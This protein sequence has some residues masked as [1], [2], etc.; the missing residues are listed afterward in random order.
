MADNE[1]IALIEARLDKT[2]L[3]NEDIPK[4]QTRLDKKKFTAHIENFKLNT[5]N[6][7]NQIQASLDSHKFTIY[8]DGIKMNDIDKQATAAG[9]KYSNSFA[10]A[11]KN[12]E[13]N[14]FVGLDA[15]LASVENRFG[16]VAN[17]GHQMTSKIGRHIQTLK[18]DIDAI[19]NASND[20][21]R[22][23]YFEKYKLDLQRVNDELKIV[24]NEID[25]LLNK[26]HKMTSRGSVGFDSSFN[27]L[28][29]QLKDLESK[30]ASGLSSIKSELQNVKT[31]ADLVLN[32]KDVDHQ[33][34]AFELWENAIRSV[35][36]QLKSAATTIDPAYK[37]MKEMVGFGENKFKSITE[38]LRSKAKTTSF[39][40]TEITS[41]EIEDDLKELE[42]LQKNIF[43]ASKSADQL[44]NWKKFENLVDRITDKLNL[45][46][47]TSKAYV[48]SFKLTKVDNKFED[49]LKRNT[50]A[51][52][53]FGDQIDDIKSKIKLLMDNAVDGRVSADGYNEVVQAIDKVQS[54]AKSTGKIG[55]KF[56][57]QLGNAFKKFS[58]YFTVFDAFNKAR[59]MIHAMYE[60][61]LAVDTAMTNL[62]KVTDETDARY[63]S[64]LKNAT[65]TAQELGRTV[66]GYV[67]Q[68]SEWA[69]LGYSLG[70]SEELSK[71][72]S[73]YA[74]VGDIDD[75]QAVSDMVTALKAFRIE[76]TDAIKV[77]D[78]LNELGELYCPYRI[79]RLASSYIG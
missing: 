4:I 69:K 33:V 65:K 5:K 30:G 18:H 13:R 31:Y 44:E 15:A 14:K 74:N 42:T 47:N 55:L 26:M 58:G 77:V 27:S 45:A 38:G 71:I 12:L 63:D 62:Y 28:N 67:T 57:D 72:S 40:G 21:S 19:K 3:E 76:S 22:A 35:K 24:S 73:I 53:A 25:P 68:A 20:A 16:K 39:G 56:S 79:L 78:Q 6:L 49:W 17:S 2:R 34:A 54:S 75:A 41:K 70:E 36:E 7:P 43:D 37:K 32:S 61:V 52:A 9:K 60:N 11:L 59:Q 8:L 64:F 23:K 29:K 10:K 1:F 51:S 50:K 46:K 48:D 66:S